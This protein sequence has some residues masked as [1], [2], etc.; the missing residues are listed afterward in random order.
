MMKEN[1]EKDLLNLLVLLTG[2]LPQLFGLK[3]IVRENLADLALPCIHVPIQVTNR[4]INENFS[5]HIF[6]EFHGV[7]A[8]ENR[9]KLVMSLAVI[10]GTK[11]TDEDC[12]TRL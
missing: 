1:E 4:L 9:Y 2:W 11:H 6:G 12:S 5:C 8:T 7:Y 3:E 10:R